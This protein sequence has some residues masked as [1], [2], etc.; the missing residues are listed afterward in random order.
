MSGSNLVLGDGIEAHY[1]EQLAGSPN[2][3]VAM[4]KAHGDRSAS[5]GVWAIGM[6]AGDARA[7]DDV[8]PAWQ[9][10]T[11]RLKVA[12]FRMTDFIHNV[13]PHH[14]RMEVMAELIPL[15]QG[16]T[17]MGSIAVMTEAD[18]NSL[19]LAGRQRLATP[20]LVLATATFG[21]VSKWRRDNDRKDTLAAVF[22]SG[23]EE[24]TDIFRSTTRLILDRSD[25]L[26]SEFGVE[27]IVFAPKGRAGLVMADCLAWLATHYVPEIGRDDGLSRLLLDMIGEKR[28]IIRTFF[29][30]PFLVELALRNVRT[31]KLVALGRQLGLYDG[32]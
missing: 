7:W 26:Q 24:G 4:L 3:F 21:Q 19:P 1:W 17:V 25:W 13:R 5:G 27:D 15:M 9:D 8:E 29:R 32:P 18:W 6:F 22:E 31:P 12:P 20:Y 11:R 30:R 10:K 2:L 14:R 16:A 28:K 23:R